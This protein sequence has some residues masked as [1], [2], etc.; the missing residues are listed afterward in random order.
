MNGSP[1]V[2][3]DVMTAI[4]A[5]RIVAEGGLD[6]WVCTPSGWFV[7]D[8]ASGLVADEALEAGMEPVV[9]ATFTEEHLVQA[10]RITGA[11]EDDALLA[12]CEA[13]ARETFDESVTVSRVRP[14][15]LDITKA[16]A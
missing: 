9:V 13:Q 12:A 16:P 15:R 6:P 7:R 3:I 2:T 5:M 11:S 10:I 8:A 14:S 4:R 1:P